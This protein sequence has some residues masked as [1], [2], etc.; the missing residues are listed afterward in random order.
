MMDKTISVL[1]VE[2]EAFS[3]LYLEDALS[4]AGYTICDTVA[5]GEG[6]VAIAENKTPDI[7]LMDIRL[8][9]EIDGIEAASRIR[10]SN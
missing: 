2:D 3:A 9:G 1:I 6:A 10:Q 8:A 4:I 5:T 7:I